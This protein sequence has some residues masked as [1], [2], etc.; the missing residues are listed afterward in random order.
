MAR[1]VLDACAG[2]GV[3]EGSAAVGIEDGIGRAP[4]DRRAV[5]AEVCRIVPIEE[6]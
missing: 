3:Q 6:G 1:E 4:D 2:G 5:S